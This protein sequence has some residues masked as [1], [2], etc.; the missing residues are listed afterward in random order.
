M[1]VDIQLDGG[2]ARLNCKG[3]MTIVR[4]ADFKKT[5]EDILPGSKE[6]FIDLMAVTDMDISFLQLL[7]SANK[8][9][10]QQKIPFSLKG[11]LTEMMQQI[12]LDAGYDFDEKYS[13]TSCKNC[14]WKGEL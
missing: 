9:F 11:N 12:L 4:I 7:C 5:I 1:S 8:T 10:E 6:V 14:F 3:E 2:S 13:D